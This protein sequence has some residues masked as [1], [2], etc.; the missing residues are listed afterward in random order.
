MPCIIK[1]IDKRARLIHQLIENIQRQDL[2][3]LEEAEAIQILI[4]NRRVENPNYSQREAA[5]ELGLPKSYIN[6]MLTLLKLPQDIKRSVWT[7]D[8]VPKSLLLLLVRQGD[9]KNIREFYK[10]IKERRLTVREVKTRLKRLKTIR[11]RPK[12]YE[13]KFQAPEKDFTVKIKF[14]KTKV[15]QSEIINALSQVLR[16]LKQER[17]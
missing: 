16:S 8:T 3:A 7:S 15:D 14:K 4:G 2:P 9:E 13:Y 1:N 11:G 10:Q 6:E 17:V 5:R 12:Y